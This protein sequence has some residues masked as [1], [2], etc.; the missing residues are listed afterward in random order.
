MTIS[1]VMMKPVHP[2]EM[3]Q[4][5]LIPAAAFRQ[6][7]A[8]E[9]GHTLKHRQKLFFAGLGQV[10]DIADSSASNVNMIG[11]HGRTDP[12]CDSLVFRLGIAR[13][14]Y[15]PA[16]DPSGEPAGCRID[17]RIV[18]GGSGDNTYSHHIGLSGGGA[19]LDVPSEWSW[20]RIVVPCFADDD[21]YAIVTLVDHARLI[22][23]SCWGKGYAEESNYRIGD[24][25]ATVGS[26]IINQGRASLAED[27]SSKW[28]L[29]AAQLLNAGFGGLAAQNDTTTYVNPFD[30]STSVTSTTIG[31]N[32]ETTRHNTVAQATVPVR[33]AVY[34]ET[35]AGSGGKVRI[36]H[37]SGNVA[38]ITGI[39]T[40]VE[41]FTATGSIPAGT[42]KVDLQIAGDG[43]NVCGVYY[44][45]LYELQT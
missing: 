45:S 18:G 25:M 28:R 21:F 5:K 32:I 8:A 36:R 3:V 4:P 27:L 11:F 33:L 40:G 1:R 38:E 19:S 24:I 2:K 42:T 12:W 13:A 7:M 35:V 44:V 29:G 37:A 6:R 16:E 43:T 20:P 34:A 9:Y 41:W 22:T 15:T 39:N 23:A 14:N 10:V 30:L 31:W 26:P 17:I